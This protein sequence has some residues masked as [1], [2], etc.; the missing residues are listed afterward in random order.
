MV[1]GTFWGINKKCRQWRGVGFR[2]MVKAKGCNH[3][4]PIFWSVAWYRSFKSFPLMKVL[5]NKCVKTKGTPN[6]CY[7]SILMPLGSFIFGCPMPTP[8]PTS[9]SL[10]KEIRGE[11]KRFGL[12][13]CSSLPLNFLS[14][15][16]TN[17]Y[18]CLFTHFY[19][20]HRS[21]SHFPINSLVSQVYVKMIL[22]YFLNF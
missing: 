20:W 19:M 1:E 4:E 21:T 22:T 3:T 17:W 10:I 9:I 7:S 11:K 16:L 13:H 14:T 15:Q 6:F 2:N 12:S 8:M 5:S 18:I